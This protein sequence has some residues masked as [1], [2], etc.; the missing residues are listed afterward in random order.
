MI[1]VIIGGSGS[2]KSVIIK[3]IMGLFKAD[4]GEVRVFGTDITPLG[5]NEMIPIRMRFGMLFQH[6]ALL[7]SLN[8]FENI[9]FPLRERTKLS[10][11]EIKERV[12]EICERVAITEMMYR[13]TG[14]ISEGQK[15]R[16]GLA[17]AI[18]TKPEVLIYDEPTTGQDPIRTRQVDDMIVEAQEMF[19]IT[20]IVISH[21]M[22]S[23]FRVAHR[24][25]MLN[26]GKI[27]AYGTPNDLMSSADPQVHHFIFAGSGEE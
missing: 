17:R 19:K 2:G 8:I 26:E 27:L 9:A 11:K 5:R 23:T 15:K 12:E 6:A 14:E 13:S 21:D 16:V 3:H 1:T 7:D 20:T 18:I 10:R 24:I 22:A 25:A 4:R